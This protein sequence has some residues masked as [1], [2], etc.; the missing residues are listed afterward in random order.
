MFYECG[1]NWCQRKIDVRFVNNTE[2]VSTGGNS[3]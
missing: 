3:K 1:T 2:V